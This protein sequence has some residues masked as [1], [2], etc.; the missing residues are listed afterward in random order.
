M[1]IH[2]FSLMFALVGFG[3]VLLL[4]RILR[5]A[6]SASR[7]ASHRGLGEGTADL[8]NYAALVED[9]IVVG[10]DGSLMAAW[11]YRCGDAASCTEAEQEQLASQINRA[12]QTLGAGWMVHIDAVRLPAPSY[13]ARTSF[14]DPITAAIDDERRAFFASRG[15]V[16]EGYSIL[17]ATYL[18]PRLTESRFVELMFEDDRPA[19]SAKEHGEHIIK[20]F[21][22]DLRALE[23]R[24]PFK[25]E[26]LRAHLVESEHGIANHD[27]FLRWLHYC[28]TGVS[29]PIAVPKSAAYLDLLIGG[30]D[31]WG[32]VVPKIGRHFVQI[33]ALEGLPLESYPGM[34]NA[35][36]ELPCEYRWSSRFIFLD[37]HEAVQHLERFRRKWRQKVRGVLD[38]VLQSHTGA[39]DHDALDMVSDAEA[40]ISDVNSGLVAQG[41]Y[42]SCVVLMDLD[43]EV[44]TR[45]AEQT[46]RVVTRLGFAARIEDVNTLEAWLGSLP[47]H[48]V[49]NVRRPLLNTFNFAD[50]L[51][52][53]TIWAGENEAPC[54]YYPPGSPP[55][56][57]CMT[58]GATPFRL[59]LHVRDVGHTLMF[60]PTGSGKSTHLA[61]LAAQ[62][63][64][65]PGL[66]LY[67]FDKG[68]SLYPLVSA[69]RASTAGRSGLHFELGG[70]GDL[71]FA[72]LQF[73]ETRS[74]RA[75]AME[76]ID[77]VLG[78]NGLKTSAEQRNEIARAVLNMHETG[79]RS[80]TELVLTLQD[81]ELRAVLEQYTVRGSMGHLL[82]APRDGLALSDFT[83]FEIEELMSL[84]DRFALPVLWYL[85]R[86]I[87]RSLQGRPSAILL[88]EAWLML[89]HPVFR[90]K[91]RQ[92]LKVLRKAN[93]LVVLATQS[94]SDAA[95]SGI[96]DVLTE[97]CATKIFL[98]NPNAREE[99]AAALY[100]GMGLNAR[101][102]EIL[103]T[104]TPKRHYYYVSEQG[105]RL[106]E[107][108]L[109]PVALAFCGAS[110]KEDLEVIRKLEEQHRDG[111]V[112]RWLE[113]RRVSAPVIGA[114]A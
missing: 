48:G 62:L 89:G 60:G 58:T 37:T 96:L 50:L 11:R 39:I 36:A 90:E 107:L 3:L 61:M 100:Q 111:W 53:S 15:A 97:S 76:W 24:L 79:S 25:L 84:G 26:R 7:I 99:S 16:F 80:L 2:A 34:L 114:A 106:Y 35:L 4:L 13:P 92:W 14:P 104:A 81:Q 12:F 87:E 6:R 43:R 30:Q 66:Q 77:L 52:S 22:R 42:T 54:P 57:Q 94:L 72:P 109:G 108:S 28:I 91:I 21:K 86:R 9:G 88:D 17:S 95:R 83:V 44:V 73:L 33:V 113:R 75:W 102:I 23:A 56:M 78:L 47:G 82:D 38:Q 49:Q 67:A 18:P 40:A 71:A 41:Y 98:P 65:Y 68:L 55:L 93:C 110:G 1:I 101:Q 5:T 32:G 59:N 46:Y 10:K 31:L 20:A 63:R 105:R 8:L 51:P 64:R 74:D 103:A 112:A 19:T 85:F 70:D 29:Q 69:V 45:A 27:D